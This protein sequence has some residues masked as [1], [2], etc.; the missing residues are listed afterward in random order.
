[1]KTLHLDDN[2]ATALTSALDSYLDGYG[3]RKG[4]EDE[5]TLEALYNRLEGL[6][7]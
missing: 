4:D 5:A 3:M 2:E 1:M 7:A 6:G